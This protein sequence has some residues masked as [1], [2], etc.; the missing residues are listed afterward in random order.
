[1]SAIVGACYSSSVEHKPFPNSTIVAVFA[2]LLGACGGSGSVATTTTSVPVTTS[3]SLVVET[4]TTTIVKASPP[5]TITFNGSN[6]AE[7]PAIPENIV[8]Y[9]P[10]EYVKSETFR[11]FEADEYGTPLAF[12]GQMNS[13][14]N[15]FWVARW[16]SLNPDVFLAGGRLPYDADITRYAGSDIES[17]SPSTYGYI[18][19]YICERPVLK[20]G[21]SSN[22]ANLV[23]VT[24]EWQYYDLDTSVDAGPATGGRQIKCSSFNSNNELPLEP[25]DQG[26]G[27]MKAQ[28][29]LVEAGF[30]LDADGYF[31]QDTYDAVVDYQKENNLE[32]DGFI[33]KNT[34]KQL[35]PFLPGFDLN[36]NGVIDPGEIG[37]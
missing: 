3:S 13:C 31:G 5:T 6:P 15:A 12:R 18:S 37:E 21:N 33:G 30:A 34:W 10:F 20:W 17:S 29:A 2:L 11:V 35:L 26:F 14:D 36:D 8:G 7:L 16:R 22:G 1:M 27:V 19:G 4:T 9:I 32:P 23:D 24:V 25:C 28:E